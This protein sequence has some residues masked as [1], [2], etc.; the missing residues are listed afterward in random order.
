MGRRRGVPT[1]KG[2]GSRGV[3][4]AKGGG[5]VE[6]SIGGAHIGGGSYSASVEQDVASGVWSG[7][8]RRDLERVWQRGE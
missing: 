6:E 3:E 7:D 2:E 1:G 4:G 5:E 8:C